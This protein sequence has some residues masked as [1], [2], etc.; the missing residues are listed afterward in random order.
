MLPKL[1]LIKAKHAARILQL[2]RSA[3]QAMKE[4]ETIEAAMDLE[5]AAEVH[6]GYIDYL[7]DFKLTFEAAYAQH[8]EEADDAAPRID[9]CMDVLAA[10]EKDAVAAF[11]SETAAAASLPES[12]AAAAAPA[13]ET[14]PA[15]EPAVETAPAVD[16]ADVVEEK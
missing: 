7:P 6:D 16:A 9:D 1:K 3:L 12:A 13:V 4:I 11:P 10:I 8:A 2:S 14:A 5:A 15:V